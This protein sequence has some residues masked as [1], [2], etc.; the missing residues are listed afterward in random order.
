MSYFKNDTQLFPE[1]L[2]KSS[3]INYHSVFSTNVLKEHK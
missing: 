1:T 3:F 2:M